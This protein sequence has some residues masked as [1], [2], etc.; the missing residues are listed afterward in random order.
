MVEP[1]HGEPIT[2]HAHNLTRTHALAHALIKQSIVIPRTRFHRS[3]S[4]TQPR[5]STRGQTLT[6]THRLLHQWAAIP[7]C[8]TAVLDRDTEITQVDAPDTSADR[9]CGVDAYRG[10]LAYCLDSFR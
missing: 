5:I 1:E 2:K 4:R 8:T 3:R 7:L 6:D 9:R 10:R